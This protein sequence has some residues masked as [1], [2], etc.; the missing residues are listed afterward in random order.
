MK[1]IPV[2]DILDGLAVHA[3]LGNRREY[4]PLESVLCDLPDPLAVASAFKAGGFAELY[5]AD[6]NA[7]MRKGE[8][9]AVINEIAEK[10]DLRLMVDAGVSD[11]EKMHQLFLSKVS[12]AVVGTETLACLTFVKDAVERFGKDRIIISLDLKNGKVLSVSEQIASMSALTLA[13][14]FQVL[15][16]TQIIVLNLSRVGS[17]EGVD[18]QLLRELSSRSDMHVNVGGG[19]RNFQDLKTLKK[20]GVSGALVATALHSGDINVEKLRAAGML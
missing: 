4:K 13:Q 18:L 17:G 11:S 20:M 15:G 8:N 7:I 16:V 19:V 9:Y 2:V 1:V 14:E 5:I 12:K 10:T 6:L 3:M